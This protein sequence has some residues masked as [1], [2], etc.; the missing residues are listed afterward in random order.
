MKNDSA[1]L[2]LEKRY[3]S[4]NKATTISHN[5]K[6]IWDLWTWVNAETVCFLKGMIIF[7]CWGQI[8]LTESRS[9]ILLNIS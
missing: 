2:H 8:I 5:L 1:E 4:Y 9:S 3:F 6:S 7:D